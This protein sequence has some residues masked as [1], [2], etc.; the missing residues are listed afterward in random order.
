MKLKT[1][2]GS[3]T[4][5][6]L[7][8]GGTAV[9]QNIEPVPPHETG[10]IPSR[11]GEMVRV[12]LSKVLK[13]SAREDIEQAPVEGFLPELPILV[14]GVKYTAKQIQE[15]DIHLSHYVLDARSAE[16]AVVQGFRTTADVTKYFNQTGQFPSEQPTGAELG[17][18]NPWSVFFEHSWYGGAN[19]SVYPGWG[20]NTLGWWNDRISSMWSTQCGRWT[21]MT[22]HHYFGGHQLWVARAWA[23]GNMGSYGW[24]T[25]WWP[26]R[27]WHSWNDRVS[28][29]AV[30]W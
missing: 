13:D 2:I 25:G 11:D 22:E 29:V 12:P 8:T 18:C 6:T 4:L 28:S 21:V 17:P 19:F 20:Y 5:A 23:V 26:F 9:A 1:L 10:E 16:Q 30:Y 24:Y 15:K 3:L 14:D 7:L 27:R